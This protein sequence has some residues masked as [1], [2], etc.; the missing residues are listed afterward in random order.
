MTSSVLDER[1]RRNRTK[2]KSGS[3][4]I[5]LALMALAGLALGPLFARSASADAVRSV[6]S[7]NWSDPGIWSLRKVPRTGDQ[8][9]IG[10]GTTVTYDVASDE[11]IGS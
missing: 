6:A 8:V 11:V 2:T 7:G 4:V 3:L 5:L 10:R 1:H 9:S